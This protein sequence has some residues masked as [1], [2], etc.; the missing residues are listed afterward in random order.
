[1]NRRAY[2]MLVLQP[3]FCISDIKNKQ[4][5]TKGEREGGRNWEIGIDIYTQTTATLYTLDY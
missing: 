3:K 2:V 1:M 4:I 5:D